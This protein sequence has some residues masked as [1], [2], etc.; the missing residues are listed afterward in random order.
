MAYVFPWSSHVAPAFQIPDDPDSDEELTANCGIKDPNL[1]EEILL[2]LSGCRDL[3]SLKC[4]PP[5]L[6]C[7]P[8]FTEGAAAARVADR[9]S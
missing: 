5:E 6:E 2:N 8:L 4:Y 7:W 1:L 3:V 9:P